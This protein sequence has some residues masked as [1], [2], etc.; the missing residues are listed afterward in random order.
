MTYLIFLA[1]FSLLGVV[2]F[3]PAF[4]RIVER[5]PTGINFFLTL[6]ATLIGVLLAIVISDYEAKQNEKQDVIKLLTSAISSVEQ[7]HQYSVQIVEYY[8]S[9]PPNEYDKKLFF[10]QNTPPYPAYLD[11]FL[12]QNMVSTNLSGTT[13][14]DLNEYLI[15]IKRTQN[16]NAILYIDMLNQIKQLLGLEITYQQGKIDRIELEARADVLKEQL[17]LKVNAVLTDSQH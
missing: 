12:A 15:N 1:I 11:I 6:L 13:L 16:Y 10:Q 8:Q 3:V 4:T 7:C 9:L 5:Y 17:Q 2:T 14:N